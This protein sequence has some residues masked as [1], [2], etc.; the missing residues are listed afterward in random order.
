[1]LELSV[2]C[3]SRNTYFS[4]AAYNPGLEVFIERSLVSSY[5]MNKLSY[6]FRVVSELE[7]IRRYLLHEG[8]DRCDKNIVGDFT[9]DR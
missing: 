6:L 4:T 5:L 3:P 9:E 2:I 8:Q 1:M 7:K